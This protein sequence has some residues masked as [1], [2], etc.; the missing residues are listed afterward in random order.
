MHPVRTHRILYLNQRMRDSDI[1]HR[2]IYVR[3][4]ECTLEEMGDS[5]GVD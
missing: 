3:W 2:A 1:G 5:S 4:T